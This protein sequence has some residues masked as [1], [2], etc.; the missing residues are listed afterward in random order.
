[1]R[2]LYPRQWAVLLIF[3]KCFSY[4]LQSTYICNFFPWSGDGAQDLVF[5]GQ[6][7]YLQATPAP[8]MFALYLF[9]FNDF[10]LLQRSAL[11]SDFFSDLHSSAAFTVSHFVP[12]P[13]CL[14]EVVVSS[15]TA[16]HSA[17][18]K[19]HSSHRAVAPIAL[20]FRELNNLPFL[21]VLP[22]FIRSYEF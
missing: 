5:T 22:R 10:P 3:L 7:L 20:G 21:A 18:S 19:A 15:L 6:D 2:G 12:L 11:A 17:A 9:F 8:L 16:S 13:G 14:E 1:M 4:I